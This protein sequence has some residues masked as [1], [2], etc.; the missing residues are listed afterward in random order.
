M[1]K[2]SI[3]IFLIFPVLLT[4]ALVFTS[5]DDAK[6]SAEDISDKIIRLHVIANS[7]S[8]E[9]QALKLKIKEAIVIYMNDNIEQDCSMSDVQ[10]FLL[11]NDETIQEIAINIIEDNGYNYK[12]NT[13]LTKCYFPI[14]SYG[15]ATFPAGEYEA[16]RVEI[17]NSVGKNW[18]CVLYPP[19][20]F[21]DA[22]SGFLPDDS[23]EML[24]DN[25][26]ENNYEGIVA[27]EDTSIKFR[28]KF[29]TFLNDIF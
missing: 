14:K 17:G 6:V 23:K 10:E 12:I 26:G 11:H 27:E 2:K 29:L 19:L 18:W 15:D 4:I 24:K 20:C 16:Y 13:E 21:V 7:D 22:S 28:F 1:S 25:L 5:K 3:F 9:D 8:D